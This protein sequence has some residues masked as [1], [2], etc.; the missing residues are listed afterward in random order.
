[1]RYLEGSGV[2]NDLNCY[3]INVWPLS[4]YN[5]DQT[6]SHTT[7]Y[8]DSSF[9]Q[10]YIKLNLKEYLTYDIHLTIFSAVLVWL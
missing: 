9:V 7:H 3:V 10:S 8:P 4:A 2:Q 6:N 1:M 5:T